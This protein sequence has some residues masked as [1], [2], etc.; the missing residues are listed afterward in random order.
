MRWIYL[1]VL[2]APCWPSLAQCAFSATPKPDQT[3]PVLRKRLGAT[4]D[5]SGR[6]GPLS[7]RLRPLSNDVTINGS[8]N[9]CT[10]HESDD[11]DLE[12][13]VVVSPTLLARFFR[14]SV[15]LPNCVHVE[16]VKFLVTRDG[17]VPFRTWHQG[18]MTQCVLF[19]VGADKPT[20][21]AAWSGDRNNDWQRIGRA[22]TVEVRGTLVVD[23]AGARPVLEI[24]PVDEV[25]IWCPQ[26]PDCRVK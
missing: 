2:A 6:S 19:A 22:N 26:S 5:Y 8:L 13:D 25:R 18:C 4:N 24:H 3:E 20:M 14:T 16:I 7:T 21:M 1:L 12:F 11:G 15:G 10:I 17:V 23:T 9:V